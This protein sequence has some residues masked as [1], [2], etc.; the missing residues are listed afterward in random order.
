MATTKMSSTKTLTSKLPDGRWIA[1]ELRPGSFATGSTKAAAEAAIRRK[2][3]AQ[4][5]AAVDEDAID[6][7]II[8]KR[9][10]NQ[11]LYPL[12]RLERKFLS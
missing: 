3:K 10:K 7:E 5:N 4:E 11:R 9:K 2:M 6:R 8:R 12:E 1:V